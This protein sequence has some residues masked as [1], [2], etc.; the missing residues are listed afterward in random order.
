MFASSHL[1]LEEEKGQVIHTEV[2]FSR[3]RELFTEF[4]IP[5]GKTSW[6]NS[7]GRT[8]QLSTLKQFQGRARHGLSQHPGLCRGAVGGS[9]P[10]LAT[11]PWEG[12]LILPSTLQKTLKKQKNKPHTGL[13][14]PLP[15]G[16]EV[17][18]FP[19]VPR[20]SSIVPSATPQGYHKAK[21]RTGNCHSL[22]TSHQ[23]PLV[24]SKVLGIENYLCDYW[25]PRDNKSD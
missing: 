24:Q 14:L 19:W 17:S 13:L 6:K 21:M 11:L 25:V 12:T 5:R 15:L 22:Y 18:L 23:L 7:E 2:P 10:L 8:G 4:I 3:D 16:N 9:L 20:A 1:P